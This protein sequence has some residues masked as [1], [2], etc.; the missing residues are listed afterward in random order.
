M[1]WFVSGDL[2]DVMVSRLVNFGVVFSGLS[3]LG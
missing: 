1:D 3:G 2:I